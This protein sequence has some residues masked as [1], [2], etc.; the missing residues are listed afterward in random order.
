M[1][2]CSCSLYS[3]AQYEKDED[4]TGV[5]GCAICKYEGVERCPPWFAAAPSMSNHHAGF[6]E[7]TPMYSLIV[8]KKKSSSLSGGVCHAVTTTIIADLF[9]KK[10]VWVSD[11]NTCK[12]VLG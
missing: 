4:G 5:I 10:L 11:F 3:S 7:V 6:G 8:G 1:S 12:L 9:L 2:V